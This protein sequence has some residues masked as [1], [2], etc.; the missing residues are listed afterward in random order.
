MQDIGAGAGVPTERRLEPEEELRVFRNLVRSL[1][2]DALSA[3]GDLEIWCQNLDQL[4]R[5]RVLR[6]YLDYMHRLC[7]GRA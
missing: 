6:R 3:I 5:C 7:D 1:A 2:G 4:E